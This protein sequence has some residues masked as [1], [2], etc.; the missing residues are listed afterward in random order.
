MCCRFWEIDKL[1]TFRNPSTI[2]ISSQ[3]ISIDSVLPEPPLFLR[4]DVVNVNYR[5]GRQPVAE[6]C[7][8]IRKLLLPL[9]STSALNGAKLEFDR[10]DWMKW[11]SNWS[12]WFVL[13]DF[14]DHQMLLVHIA[15][16]LLPICIGFRAYEFHLSFLSEKSA[17]IVISSI[18]GMEPARD[19]ANVKFVIL[20]IYQPQPTALPEE[21][22]TNWFFHNVAEERKRKIRKNKSLEIRMDEISNGPEIQLLNEANYGFYFI[23]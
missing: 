7:E 23:G 16:D 11:W 22:I 6:K 21:A 1:F 12:K 15:N 5:P 20:G 4:F 19:C 9:K 10:N 17:P 14:S 8:S 13:C 2:H 3:L 18:L